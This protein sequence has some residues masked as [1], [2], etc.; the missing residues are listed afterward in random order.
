MAQSNLFLIGCLL[1]EGRQ[2]KEKDDTLLI[3]KLGKEENGFKGYFGCRI[4]RICYWIQLCVGARQTKNQDDTKFLG[5]GK[6]INADK[7]GESLF[8]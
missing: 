8:F 7:R 1:N 4:S 5:M 3:R 6:W 2:R